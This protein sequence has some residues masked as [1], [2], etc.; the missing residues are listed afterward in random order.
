M[1]LHMDV[2]V[3]DGQSVK[4]FDQHGGGSGQYSA[5]GKYQISIVQL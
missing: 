4:K 1:R 5:R 2:R 3:H